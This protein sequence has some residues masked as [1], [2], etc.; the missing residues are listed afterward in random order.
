MTGRSGRARVVWTAAVLLV[1]TAVFLVGAVAPTGAVPGLD[2]SRPAGARTGIPEPAGDT[3]SEGTSSSSA[4]ASDFY[5]APRPLPAGK[6]GAL[7]RSRPIAAPPGAVGWKVLY[8]SRDLD[9]HDIAVSGVVYA[10][11]GP[12]PPGGRP[13]V[14]WAHATTGV[15]DACAPSRGPDPAGT[16]PW[17]RDLLDEGYVVAATDYAGLGTDGVHP[18]LV[19]ALE[20]RSVLDSIRAARH[21]PTGANRTAAVYGHSQGGH[22]ALFAGEVAGRY[23]PDI[24]LRGVAAGA[25]VVAPGAF[26]DDTIARQDTLGFLVLGALGSQG[27]YPELAATPLLSI[28]GSER[29]EVAAHGCAM[30][31]FEEFTGSDPTSVFAADPRTVGAWRRRLDENAAGKRRSSAPV[32]LWQGSDDDLTRTVHADAYA[33]R[34]CRHGTVLDYRVYP[35]ADHVSVLAAAGDDVLGF[36]EGVLAGARAKDTC[37]ER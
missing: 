1:G 31:V 22:A 37:P 24:A 17:I 23:A 30:D 6:P 20:G 10:P 29:A 25:P 36:L 15:G 18:Y 34:A 16:I 3:V 32:L 33:A 5:A 13:V 7:I 14:A 19:G 11:E 2:G 8:H 27:A 28:V 21:L 12:A 9:G 26:V 35:G 4:E